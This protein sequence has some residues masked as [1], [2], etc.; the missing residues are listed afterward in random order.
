MFLW[1]Q[2]QEHTS[3]WFGL[4]TESD[5][6]TAVMDVLIEEWTS[7]PPNNFAPSIQN[8][9][10]TNKSAHENIIVNS[11]IQLEASVVIEDEDDDKLTYE[12][13]IIPESTDKKTGGDKERAPRPLKGFFPKNSTSKSIVKF[14]TPKKEGEYR[15]FLYVH[16]GN[17]NVATGN[18]PFKVQD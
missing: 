8:F 4:F 18:I 1:G 17:G 16:D 13:Q 10:L 6:E 5:E 15:L 3:T 9:K 14:Y 7:K 2:K 11:T 12:W